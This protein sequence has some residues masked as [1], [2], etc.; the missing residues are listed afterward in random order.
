MARPLRIQFDGAFQ[1]VTARGD[2]RESIFHDDIDAGMFESLLADVVS[3]YRWRCHAYVLMP[4][5]YHLL[6]ETPG[7]ELSLGMRQ[8]NGVYTQRFNRRYETTGHVFQGRFHSELIHK[9]SHLTETTRYIAL[10][11]V[12]AGLVKRP[13]KWRRSS[14]AATAGIV[15]A[16]AWLEVE[17]TL[18]RFADDPAVARAEFISF[19]LGDP[20]RWDAAGAGTRPWE[21]RVP[22]GDRASRA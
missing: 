19:V 8:L 15:A 20:E 5:H 21:R 9:E 10:N 4:N 13:E 14:Y 3:R 2:R 12:R 17:M 1:H 18:K 11:P 7:G 22:P 16:P 6:I